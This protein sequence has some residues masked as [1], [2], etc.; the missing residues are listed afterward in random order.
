MNNC[1]SRKHQRVFPLVLFL[2]L[3]VLFLCMSALRFAY[4]RIVSAAIVHN[5]VFVNVAFEALQ[6]PFKPFFRMNNNF[7]QALASFAPAKA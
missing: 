4:K 7:C 1:H 6:G 5:A 2:S 3:L